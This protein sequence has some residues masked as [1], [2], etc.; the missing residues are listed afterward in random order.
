MKAAERTVVVGDLHGCLEELERLLDAVGFTARD[1]LIAVGDLVGKGPDGAGVVRFLRTGG[2]E[3]VRGNH[4]AKLLA[5]RRGERDR[6][7][8]AKH[9]AHAEAM[10]DADWAWLDGL[11]PWLQ[12]PDHGAIV[13]HGG[14]VPG[15]PLEAQDPDVVTNL[16]SIRPDG[17]PSQRVDEGEPWA[18]HW[19]GP[20]LVIFGHDAIRGLQRWEHAVGLDT[21]CVYGLELSALMLPDRRIVSVPSAHD[22]AG[23]GAPSLEKEP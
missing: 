15:V 6:P 12:L 18:K 11:P 1:R 23:G 2:H 7:L 4:D 3:A 19:P 21:G 14:L 5:A 9:R 17:T 16:R 10:D 20:E 22:Y 8:G 13:V